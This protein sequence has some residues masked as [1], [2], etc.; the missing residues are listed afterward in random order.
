MET[1]C[2]GAVDSRMPQGDIGEPREEGIRADG[3]VAEGVTED[4]GRGI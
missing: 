1:R 2:W 3:H 4:T